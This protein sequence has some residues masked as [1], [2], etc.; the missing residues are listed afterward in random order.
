MRI[1]W[2]V[3]LLLT[4]TLAQ[5][6]TSIIDTFHEPQTHCSYGMAYPYSS[7]D[8]IG[9]EATYDI[10][11]LSA[12]FNGNTTDIRILLNYGNPN[13]NYAG[14]SL[15]QFTDENLALG[16]GDLLFFNPTN[17]DGTA[18]NQPAYQYGV[19]LANRGSF[20]A[21]DVYQVGNGIS[22]ETADQ[23]IH[24]TGYY[25][26][27]NQVVWLT[28]TPSPAGTGGTVVV[29]DYGDGITAAKY[30]VD[31]TFTDP[32]GFLQNLRSSG[33]IGISFASADC[34][35]DIV[36]GT[37]SAPEPGSVALFGSMCLLLFPVLRKIG[38]R[39]A[40]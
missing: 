24:N 26:R 12:S 32:A 27:R 38:H 20:V 39:R 6:D 2:A 19:P 1:L 10:Q 31:L 15:N 30:E 33:Q 28:G 11:S 3:F 23:A 37:V 29:K 40:H 36:M 16:I 4:A 22:T 7:C 14:G 18:K 13:L 34:A 9:N 17:W 35:N 25:Y 8:V 5:A 21:G